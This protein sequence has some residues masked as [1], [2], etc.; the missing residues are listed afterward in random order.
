MHKN[1]TRT[2]SAIFT[3]SPN[4]ITNIKSFFSHFHSALPWFDKWSSLRGIV[5]QPLSP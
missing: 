2:P 5:T 4:D 1:T 3:I